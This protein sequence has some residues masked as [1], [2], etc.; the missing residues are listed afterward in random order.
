MPLFRSFSLIHSLRI[1]TL[2]ETFT[3]YRE[4]TVILCDYI[5]QTSPFFPTLIFVEFCSGIWFTDPAYLVSGAQSTHTEREVRY[6][7]LFYL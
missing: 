1:F 6:K 3:I 5:L 4:S 2:I 7:E